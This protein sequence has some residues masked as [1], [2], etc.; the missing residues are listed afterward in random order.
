[1]T[2]ARTLRALLGSTAAV[3]RG[4]VGRELSSL[5]YD[6]RRVGAGSVFVAIPGFR[7]DGIT[8]VHDAVARGAAAVV[9][10]VDPPA[11]LPEV[12][13]ARVPDAR[14]ALAAMACAWHDQ[15]SH[16]MTVVGVTGTNG[17]TTVTALLESLLGAHAPAGRWSTTLVRYGDR[18]FPTPRTTPEAPD[19]Q[20]AL[21][22]MRE[23][24]CD[25]AVIEVSSHALVLH[26]VDGTRFSAAV[27]TNLSPDHLDF[28]H[29]M[30]DYLA[31]K[32]LLFERLERDAPAIVNGSDERAPALRP[33]VRGRLVAFGW[34]DAAALPLQYAIVSASADDAGT[35]I[36]LVTPRG[37]LTVRTPLFGRAMVENVVAALTTALE[38]GVDADSALE[39]V[40]AFRG[41]P[42]RLERVDAGQD[43]TALVDFAHT[44]AALEAA[45]DAARSITRGRLVVV[46]GCGGDRDRGKR[47]L[48]GGIAARGADVSIVTSDNP[49]SEDPGAI[50]EQILGGIPRDARS[51]VR[52]EPDRH[53]AIAL[54]VGLA[55]PGDTLLVA[56]KGHE[57]QQTFADRVIEFDDRAEVAAAIRAH[58]GAR[59]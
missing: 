17:K 27:F 57:R 12:A 10:E 37:P 5:E 9:A 23:A 50:I 55:R 28:H 36:E 2:A 19:L 47:P 48:M 40:A 52:V 58:A 49:R 39:G 45:I 13:W 32:G 59:S 51:R 11:D 20:S 38:L 15:P 56:G 46:F 42:G 24:G 21:A 7:Y 43:F 18:A 26:R 54:A 6:S 22:G 25:A 1:M 16:A 30:E 44:P 3:F 41:E 35:T 4:D 33:H 14:A 8:F 53:A 29:T 34:Q 31:A